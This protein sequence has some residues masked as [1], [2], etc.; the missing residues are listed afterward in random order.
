[1]FMNNPG[2]G[3]KKRSGQAGEFFV[4]GELSRGGIPNGLL[5]ETFSDDERRRFTPWMKILPLAL[6]CLVVLF[7]AY[8]R[9]D[10]ETPRNSRVDANRTNA[11]LEASSAAGAETIGP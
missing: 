8:P 11:R 3:V 7:C 5:S 1:M 10:A 6:P 4:S 9:L 2:Q